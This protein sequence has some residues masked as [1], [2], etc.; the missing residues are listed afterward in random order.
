ME[1]GSC[2]LSDSCS[3]GMSMRRKLGSCAMETCLTETVPGETPK[4]SK[5]CRTIWT[6]FVSFM[7]TVMETVVPSGPTTSESYDSMTDHVPRLIL[8]YKKM[9]CAPGRMRPTNC[10]V[11]GNSSA[12]MISRIVPSERVSERV[13]RYESFGNVSSLKPSHRH[14]RNS[15]ACVNRL[16]FDFHKTYALAQAN[17][18]A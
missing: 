11:Y 6:V 18:F 13:K 17:L 2:T 8:S 15:Q 1:N 12:D 3:C 9:G 14:S 5:M 10:R 7:R 16:R 4:S